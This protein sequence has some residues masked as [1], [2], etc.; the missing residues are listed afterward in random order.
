M[1]RKIVWNAAAR[2]GLVL[3]AVSVVYFLVNILL[4]KLPDT[5]AANVIANVAGILLWV[6]KFAACIWLFK[7]F[8]LRF[9]SG[10]SD[11]SN[12]DTFRFGRATAFLSALV[13]SAFFLAW[14]TL[15]DPN[16]FADSLSA[17][18]QAYEGVFTE[19]QMDSLEEMAPR[20]PA[21]AFFTNLVYCYLFGVVLS[22]I[23][24]RNIP[25]R[26]PFQGAQQ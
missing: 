9:A 17:A 25:P 5:K 14:V 21:V 18:T 4:G 7:S 15:I 8:M 11:A 20:L 24:S 26:N 6:A 23:F 16:M 10:N 13:Y 1:D 22:A 19:A 2:S 12:S 3:G